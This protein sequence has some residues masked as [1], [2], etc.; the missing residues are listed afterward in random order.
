MIAHW[1][2]RLDALRRES[3]RQWIET[4]I[5]TCIGLVGLGLMGL[6]MVP[7]IYAAWRL[8]CAP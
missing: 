8:F 5:C 3:R 6:M 4:V 7:F 2:H 1:N